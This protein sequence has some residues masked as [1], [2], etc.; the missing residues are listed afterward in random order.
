MDLPE[1]IAKVGDE[2]ITRAEFDVRFEPGAQMV[3]ARRDDGKL[4]WPYQAQ[5]RVK[6]IDELVY[7]KHLELEAK[8]SGIDYDPDK[9]AKQEA[10]ERRHIKDWNAW[11]ERIGQTPEIRHHANVVFF[12][13]RA[14]FAARG[15]P[16]EAS[17]AELQA[18]YE[19]MS[20]RFTNNEQEL[21]RASHILITYG[22]REGTEKIQP[23]SD[24]MQGKADP[25]KLA[26]WDKLARERAEQLREMA[27]EPDV[28]FN[29]LAKEYSEGPGA[30]RGGDMGLFPKRQM[31]PEYSEA[32]WAL[33]PGQISEPIK[34]ERGYYVIKVFGHYQ[35]GALPFEAVRADLVRQVESDKYIQARED[36]ELELDERFP[37]TS[38]VLDEAREFR[39]E[40]KN[41][42]PARQ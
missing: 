40:N 34:S 12:R 5:Q 6:I 38:A 3:L 29:E 41:K 19:S 24:V 14:L 23:N 33:E 26:E 27:L 10:D 17:E 11:L 42:R 37:V 28:D 1:V 25:A 31:V 35:P 9:L 22:P 36:L 15:K 20:E 30:F 32:A 39:A 16:I 7:A 18:A 13:E 8:R 2:T 21:V 4:P